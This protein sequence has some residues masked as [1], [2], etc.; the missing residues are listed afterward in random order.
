M[1]K[2]P[3]PPATTP[4]TRQ[5][6][7]SLPPPPGHV[8]VGRLGAPYGLHGWLRVHSFTDPPESLGGYLAHGCQSCADDAC[9]QSLSL[10]A[11]RRADGALIARIA[12]CEDRELARRHTGQWLAVSIELLPQLEAGEYYWHQLEG[13][14]VWHADGSCLLGR[15]ECLLATGANDVLVVQPCD[16]SLDR[17]RRLLPWVP[18]EVVRDVDLRAGRLLV[19]WEPEL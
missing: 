17:R 7:D 4:Q 10:S 2:R 5:R 13:L 8:V 15:V 11:K 1:A 18:G 16:G 6:T 3:M 9:W 14:A 12:H 19:S